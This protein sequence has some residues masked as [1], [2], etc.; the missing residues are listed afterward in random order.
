[1]YTVVSNNT[2]T[3]V[4]KFSRYAAKTDGMLLCASRGHSRRRLRSLIG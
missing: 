1:V 3:R 4:G 2:V